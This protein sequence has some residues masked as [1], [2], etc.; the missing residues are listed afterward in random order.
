MTVFVNLIVS[1]RQGEDLYPS[2][3]K[4]HFGSRLP[5]WLRPVVTGLLRALGQHRAAAINASVGKKSAHEFW[6]AVALLR[7][8]CTAT[9]LLQDA[10][11]VWQRSSCLLVHCCVRGV[12]D[13]AAG[14]R[15]H[16]ALDRQWVGCAGVSRAG[17]A[18][19]HS[20]RQCRPDARVLLHARYG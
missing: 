17:T 9:W 4:L 5:R 11:M 1:Q 14:R 12:C 3:R 18:R 20:W 19:T 2:Y 16:V 10:C 7:K 6:E 15:V 13:G 8:V